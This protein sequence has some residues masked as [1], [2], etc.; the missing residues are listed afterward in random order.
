M[1]STAHTGDGNIWVRRNVKARGEWCK[2]MVRRPTVIHRYNV[3]MG[4]VDKSDQLIA[5]YNNYPVAENHEVRYDWHWTNVYIINI[6]LQINNIKGLTCANSLATSVKIKTYTDVCTYLEMWKCQIIHIDANSIFKFCQNWFI[7]MLVKFCCGFL[8][9]DGGKHMIDVSVVN[10]FI[11]FKDW[12]MKHPEVQ[13]LHFQ[14]VKYIIFAVLSYFALLQVTWVINY[15]V[16]NRKQLDVI[17]I[18]LV[19]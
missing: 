12:K 16:H 8:P 4:G 7:Y 1:L 14:Q 2:I 11:L 15:V 10:A 13:E 18:H 5:N 9:T 17:S 3:C 19:P 6:L